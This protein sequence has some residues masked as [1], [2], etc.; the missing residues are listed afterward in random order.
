[1]TKAPY[2][3]TPLIIG[4]TTPRA[5]E[6]ATAASKAFP[7]ASRTSSPA[8]VA[9]GW[10]ELTMPFV[11]TAGR[12]VVFLLAGPSTGP[13]SCP[14]AGSGVVGSVASSAVFPERWGL[15]SVVSTG[16]LPSPEAPSSR[17]PDWAPQEH[18]TTSTNASRKG[19]FDKTL[20][21]L[22][23]EP[24]E[25]LLTELRDLRRDHDLTVRLVPVVPV[26]LLVVVLGHVV[27]VERRHLGDDGVVPDALRLEIRDHLFGD[28]PLV[29]VV[30]EDRRP[31]LRP[32]VRALPVQRR[33][34]VDGEVDL[35]DLPERDDLGVESHLDD[36]G[37]AGGP[38]ADLAVRRIGDL[39]ARVAG[40][41]LLYAPQ[42]VIDRLQTPEAATA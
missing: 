20:L 21:G 18:R 23:L 12:P 22:R 40:L 36:L 15:S 4:S 5:A 41:D 2:P 37:V 29:L 35:Q 27:G 6:T 31:V 25:V 38:G 11:P 42:L 3:P 19:F 28:A 33:G 13:A 1:M 8:R 34:V 14:A 24:F 9:S 7:P 26:V 10:A 16:V 30:V 32:D 17:A 39:S